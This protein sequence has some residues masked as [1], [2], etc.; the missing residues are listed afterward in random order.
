MEKAHRNTRWSPEPRRNPSIYDDLKTKINIQEHQVV[1][2]NET[3]VVVPSDIAEDQR[4]ESN[5]S[6]ELL[7]ELEPSRTSASNSGRCGLNLEKPF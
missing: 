5:C 3:N 4:I 2:L 1:D 7:P 6:L